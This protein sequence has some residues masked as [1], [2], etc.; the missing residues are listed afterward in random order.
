MSSA[1]IGEGER[2]APLGTPTNDTLVNGAPA[3]SSS[4]NSDTSTDPIIDVT[5]QSDQLPQRLTSG[6]LIEPAATLTPSVIAPAAQA[7]VI[8]TIDPT[9]LGHQPP[10]PQRTWTAAQLFR[11]LVV[12]GL[13]TTGGAIVGWLY[14]GSAEPVYAARSEFIYFLEDA[15]PDG[16]LREDRRILTQLVTIE[17][18]AVLRP[19][20][21]EFDTTVTDLRDS[22]N[23]EVVDLSEVIRLDVTDPDS[24]RA[25]E[26]NGAVLDAYRETAEA[27][28]LDDSVTQLTERR[29]ELLDELALADLEVQTIEEAKLGDVSLAAS[30]ESLGRQLTI[31]SERLQRLS[32]M[33]DDLLTGPTTVDDAGTINAQITSSRATIESLQQQLLG[34][35]TQRANLQQRIN[36]LLGTETEFQAGPL[37]NQDV[38]LSVQEDSLSLE[39]TTVAERLRRLEGLSAETLVDTTIEPSS[40]PITDQIQIAEDAVASLES[41]ILA[42]REQRA[43]LAQ[44]A[45]TLPSMTRRVSRLEADLARVED[46]LGSENLFERPVSPIEILATPFV[47]DEPVGNPRLQFAALG[48]I[49]A[50]PFALLVVALARLRSKRH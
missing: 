47:L 1:L 26:L 22:L 24:S 35:R 43:Q 11:S 50:V 21:T 13:I 18:D 2:S 29:A 9:L 37:Q 34:V 36:N 40:A 3:M 28:R 48:F 31:E 42:V 6:A 16:F 30:E 23:V 44:N 19:I 5:D 46:E 41:Q 17:S 14:G 8:L 27:S 49:A 33:A 45:A 32:A 12:I 39:I 15:V 25:L 38:V 7:P 10:P 4:D 20:A